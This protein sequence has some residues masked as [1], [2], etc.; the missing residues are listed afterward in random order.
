L[1]R[2]FLSDFYS[3][4]FPDSFARGATF[5][6]NPKTGDRRISG[7]LAS[8]A[9]LEIALEK[10]DSVLIGQA[11][12]RILLLHSMIFGY[13][14]IPAIYMGDEIGLLND[15]SYM[16]DPDLAGDNRWMHRPAMD[17]SLA[18]ER[19]DPQTVTGRIF[20]GLLL[21]IRA[22]KCSKAL[23]SQAAAYAVWSGNESVFGLLR[24]S[25]RGRLLILGNFSELSQTIATYRLHEMGF[26][27]TLVNLIDGREY[28]SWQDIHLAPFEALWLE[29][30][31]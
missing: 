2:A 14:G 13:G 12:G 20:Q 1:H 27:G 5:Q 30:R 23:H 19:S 17:W 6:F 9:G 15:K 7:S 8:L 18:G 21:L 3:G 11:I 24:E 4:R 16:A 28:G 25:P 10:G 29:N 31:K 22:R 26:E